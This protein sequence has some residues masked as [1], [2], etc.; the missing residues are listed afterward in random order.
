MSRHVAKRTQIT[1]EEARELW[2]HAK[3]AHSPIL[4]ALQKADHMHAL[5]IALTEHCPA[6]ANQGNS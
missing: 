3:G 6:W 4:S 2:A 5:R 1:V